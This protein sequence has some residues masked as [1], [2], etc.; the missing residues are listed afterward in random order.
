MDT[1]YNNGS[2]GPF[3]QTF[4][5]VW[6][7]L[8]FAL[9]YKE[10]SSNTMTASAVFCNRYWDRICSETCP[11]PSDQTEKRVSLLPGHGNYRRRNQTFPGGATVIPCRQ[12]R[13]G[14]WRTIMYS[15]VTSPT[16]RRTSHL[17]A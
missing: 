2:N 9:L 8:F 5:F 14:P 15:C 4:K 17:L 10:K 3:I 13:R 6:S 11:G 12:G 16:S 7:A 1:I